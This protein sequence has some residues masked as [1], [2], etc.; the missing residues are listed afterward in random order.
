MQRCAVGR[1]IV[2]DRLAAIPKIEFAPP[3]AFY[4]FFRVAGV[5]DSTRFATEL[6]AG[7]GVGLAPGTAFGAVG[8]GFF[9][10][11]FA[12]SATDLETASKRLGDWLAAQP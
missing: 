4:L 10:L 6:L 5:E 9:R 7:T 8:K 2:M 12:R 1:Q 3:G 11:C